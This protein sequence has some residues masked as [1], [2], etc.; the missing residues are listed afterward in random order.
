MSS[1]NMENNLYKKA[2]RLDDMFTGKAGYGLFSNKK[3]L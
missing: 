1:S 2:T 3:F